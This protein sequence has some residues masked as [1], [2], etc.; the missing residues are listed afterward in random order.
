MAGLLGKWITNGTDAPFYARKSFTIKKEVKSAK[1]RVCGLGQFIFHINGK[2]V[3]DHE[4]DPG[5]TNYRKLIQY[6]EFDVT[7]YLVSGEN[8]MGAE[9]GNGWFIKHDE[10]YTFA[11][12][13]FMPPNPNPYRPFGKE[14]V[15]AVQLLAVYAD[16]TTETIEADDT[17]FVKKH[18]VVMSNVYGSETIDGRLEQAGW[19]SAGF[20]D[21]GWGRAKLVMQEDEPEGEMAEQLQPAVRV[22]HTYSGRLISSF[23]RQSAV[24]DIYDFGQNMSGI[25][26]LEVQGKSGDRI[27]LYPAEKLQADG[28]V[29]QVAKDWTTVDSCITYIIGQDDVWETMRM[30]FT[31]FAGR[32]VA[33]ERPSSTGIR[34]RNFYAHA[35]TSAWNAAG[36]FACDDKRYEQIY[37]LVEK[38]VEANMVS[39]HTDCPT[40]ERFAWQ[41]P[42]H[43]MAPSIMFMKDGRRLWEKFLLD[44]RT[45]QHSAEDFFYDYEGNVIH[46]GDGLM[47]SQCPYYIQM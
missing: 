13:S 2:K 30:R 45:E 32:F 27:H 16:G 3:G 7:D 35:I 8:I 42:N 9:V 22:V 36:S 20:D 34:V 46:P 28:D 39:V 6:V 11:L 24:R 23:C 15:F 4:L 26:E 31:Y 33:V 5:C 12:A 17:F 40:I 21:S 1:A 29:D 47:P 19:S 38:A 25:L 41:E 44:M 18:P 10:H 37:A 43:L 14:L